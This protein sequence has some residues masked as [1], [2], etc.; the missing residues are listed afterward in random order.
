MPLKKCPRCGNQMSMEIDAVALMM[1]QNN[2]SL[3]TLKCKACGHTEVLDADGIVGEV[4]ASGKRRKR[5]WQFW[6]R[7]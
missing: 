7:S 6:K 1:R 3:G 5:W 4:L 2:P